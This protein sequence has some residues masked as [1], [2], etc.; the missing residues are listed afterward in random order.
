[1]R[2]ASPWPQQWLAVISALVLVSLSLLVL[3]ILYFALPV[4]VSEGGAV[5]TL[6]W[7][8]EQGHFGI[9]PMLCTS[10]LLALA[11][12]M[13]AYPLALGIAGSCLLYKRHWW[14][15][16]LLR[17]IRMMAG[18][19]TVVHGIAALF[20]LIPWLREA[21][22]QGSG[23]SMLAAVLVMVLL[24]LPVMV[25]TLET[26]CAPKLQRLSLP[27]ACLGF[28]QAQVLWHLVLP[29]SRPILT[30]AAL[31]GFARA[32]GDTLLPLMLAGNAPQ[33]P[34]SPMDSVRALTAHI[35]LVLS[36]E[37]GSTLHNSLFVAGLLLLLVSVSVSLLL[38]RLMR[39]NS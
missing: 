39:A 4:L 21:F 14:G 19:P 10:I 13:L 36:T 33:F 35:G 20:I 15:R 25:M 38:R 32:I 30:S 24:I 31:L 2:A 1:M 18:I 5:M 29:Q 37:H 27:A 28:S 12:L 11:A 3:F 8:P 17:T 16:W 22:G 34:G 23:F 6:L 7:R 26:H 9:L